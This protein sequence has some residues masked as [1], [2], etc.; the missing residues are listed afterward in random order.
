[1]V[2]LWLTGAQIRELIE[3]ALAGTTP[4]LHVSGVIVRYDST[5]PARQ[6]V[7][8]MTLSNGKQI[9]DAATYVVGVTDFLALGTG[10]GYQAFGRASKRED[11]DLLD[12]DAVI[13]YLQSQPQP[14]K[15]DHSERRFQKT[16]TQHRDGTS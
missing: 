5:A 14:I 4:D 15:A 13:K 7:E 2:K 10:D 3:H 12:L 11:I 16:V 1:M 9:S 6:R 8:R